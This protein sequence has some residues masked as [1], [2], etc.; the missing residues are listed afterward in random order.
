MLEWQR[1]GR[2]YPIRTFQSMFSPTANR[3]AANTYFSDF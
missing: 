3:K 1:N 2:H